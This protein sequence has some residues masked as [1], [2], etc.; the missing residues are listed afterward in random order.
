M[1]MPIGY[2]FFSENSWK[3]HSSSPF[4]FPAVAEVGV[5]ADDGHHPALVVEDAFVVDGLAIAAV[6]G[7]PGDAVRAALNGGVDA[8]HL[9][10][11][12]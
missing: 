9:R 8:G 1:L 2:D 12:L 6:V 4:A 7:F 10:L 3:Y 5:V 11:C